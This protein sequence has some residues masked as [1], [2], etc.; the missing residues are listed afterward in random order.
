MFLQKIK[1]NDLLI[2]L[3]IAVVGACGGTPEMNPLL[4][5]ARTSYKKAEKDSMI[6]S[7]APV[8]LKEAEEALE[9]SRQLWEEGGDSELVDHYAYIARRKVSIARETA[10]LNAAQDEVERAEIRRQKVL[11][12]ARKVEAEQAEQRA[13]EALAKVQEEKQEAE[14][15]RRRAREL[16]EK[17]NE[18]EAR[19]TERGLVLTL[20]DLLFDFDKATLKSGGIRAV[21]KLSLFLQEYPERIVSIEGYTDSIGSEEYNRELSLRRADA[22]R[23]AL[24]ERGIS[25]TRIETKGYGEQYPVA[26]NNTD[27]G[28]QQN[29]RVEVVISDSQGKIAERGG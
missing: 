14:E 27:A 28:R 18:L 2:V 7:K 5:E 29:R 20:G 12:E 17:I 8:A 11:I 25:S 4:K 10:K 15:A 6:V 21:E 1:G 22:V 23:R 19:Q 3:L 26:S 16:S 24:I 13:R 9:T